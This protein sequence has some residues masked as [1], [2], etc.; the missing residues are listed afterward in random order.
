MENLGFPFRSRGERMTEH[1]N[2][3]LAVWEDDPASFDG[4]HVSFENFSLQPKPLQDPHPPIWVGGEADVALKRAAVLGDAWLPVWRLNI[5]QLLERNQVYRSY[6]DEFGRA[7]AGREQPILRLLCI[8]E[9]TET[10]RES[11]RNQL[12]A[13]VSRY[14]QRGYEVPDYLHRAVSGHFDE[15]ADG[16]F[17]YGDPERCIATIDEI[18]GTVGSNHFIFKLYNPGV[19]HEQVMEQIE[20]V[21]EEVIPQFR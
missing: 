10:A 5:D 11:L 6:L 13:L 12:E 14:Q 17:I 3:L 21:G 4:S 20:L 7:T 15:V 1:L 16:R 9:D 18:S 19:E 2:A 8:D